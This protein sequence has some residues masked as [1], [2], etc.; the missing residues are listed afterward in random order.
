[1]SPRPV[2]GSTFSALLFDMDGTLINSIAAAERVWGAWALKH[3]LDP[4]SFL[5]TIHGR[6]VSETI[7]AQKLIGVDVA[8]EAAWITARELEDVEGIVPITGAVPFL[9]S[10]PAD[11]VAIVTSAPRALALRRLVA[12]GLTPPAVIVASEDVERG[13]PAPD[14]F[15]L[16][17]RRLGVAIA[18]CLVVED[19][20]VGIAAAEASGASLLIM[21]ETH[22]SPMKTAHATIASYDTVSVAAVADRL[23][24]T[25]RA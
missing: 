18:D 19:A 11:K 15:L 10:L 12:A 1:M 21:T 25:R 14:P 20:P 5:P 22:H 8:V 17:A 7:A 13:K 23:R 9:K 24:I 3:G 6:R 4:V 16:A 2:F